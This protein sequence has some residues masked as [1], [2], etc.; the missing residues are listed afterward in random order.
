MDDDHALLL[1]YA[2]DGDQAAFA[3]L[4]ARHVDFVFNVSLRRT[5]GDADLARDVSQQVFLAAAR[6]AADLAR[7]PALLG[8]LHR[9]ACQRAAD[10]VRAEARRRA[11]ETRAATDPALAPPDEP[12]ADWSQLAPV[13]D[14]ALDTLGETDRETILLRYF[15]GQ[16]FAAIATALDTTE[17]AAQMRATRALEKLRRALAARGVTSTAS[18]LGLALT[19]HAVTA[20]PASVAA[21]TLAALASPAVLAA[22][23][24]TATATTS[25]AAIFT[26]MT[27]STKLALGVSAAVLAAAGLGWGVYSNLHDAEPPASAHPSASAAPASVRASSAKDTPAAPAVSPRSLASPAVAQSSPSATAATLADALALTDP[28]KRKLAFSSLGHDTASA[29]S[30][31]ALE[32][33]AQIQDPADRAAFIEGMM[34]AAAK[35]PPAE[36][37]LLADYL[38]QGEDRRVGLTALAANWGVNLHAPDAIDYIRTA[39]L[40][41][42][43]GVLVAV[44]NPEKGVAWAEGLLEGAERTQA[45]HDSLRQLARSNP[46]AALAYAATS[47]SPEEQ[48]SLLAGVALGW[49]EKDGSAAFAWAASHPADA[50]TRAGLLSAT[51]LFWARQDLDSASRAA[52][53]LPPESKTRTLT[54]IGTSLH[55]RDPALAERWAAQLPAGPEK[56]QVLKSLETLRRTGALIRNSDGSTTL[57]APSPSGKP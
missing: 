36:A 4:V 30:K 28:F 7:H 12:A 19:G 39:G 26:T 9:C 31:H 57:R 13:L 10:L 56:D 40:E 8:W 20:A 24:T 54:S 27:T 52:L 33:L 55:H 11:R 35:M 16:P 29:D 21:S 48:R 42:A 2:R 34:A 47:R 15:S 5:G 14:T 32:L 1:R 53:A 45:L 41:G 6:R 44:Q 37:V 25:A 46:Q 22:T 43:L 23:A 18:A 3:A 49:A 38:P 51:S 50:A 17:A